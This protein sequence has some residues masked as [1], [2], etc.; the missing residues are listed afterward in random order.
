MKALRRILFAA[1]A[2][3]MFCSSAAKLNANECCVQDTQCCVVDPCGS[4][5]NDCCCSSNMAPGLALA[6]IAVV[7]VIAIAVQDSGGHHHHSHSH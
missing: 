7:A 6:A 2:M 1:M 4:G 5:Y 3:S